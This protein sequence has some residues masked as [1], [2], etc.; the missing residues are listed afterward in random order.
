MSKT[1]KI[2]IVLVLVLVIPGGVLIAYFGKNKLMGYKTYI[3]DGNG[4]DDVDDQ[5]NKV[6]NAYRLANV[7]KQDI[8]TFFEIN[9]NFGGET[10][11]PYGTKV[12]YK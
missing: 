8:Q 9:N 7:L 11:L 5:K 10:W 2:L 6:F 3:V 1:I 4:N 12:K